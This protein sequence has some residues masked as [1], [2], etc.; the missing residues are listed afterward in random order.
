[1]QLKGGY[2]TKDVRLD[3]VPQFDEKSRDFRVRQMIH[4]GAPLGEKH[5][6]SFTWANEHWLDQGREGR[7][8]EYAIC[9]DL[10]AKPKQVSTTLVQ[11]I[12]DGKRIYWPAQQEDQW[13]GGSYEGGDPSYEGTSVLAGVKVAARLGF[14]QE[15][16]WALTLEGAV[17][18]LGYIGPLILGVNWYEGCF[19]PDNFGWIRLTGEQQGGHSILAIG[20]KLVAKADSLHVTDFASLD[21]DRSFILLHN[22]W[23]QDWGINGRA[24]MSLQDFDRLRQ[25]DGEVCIISRRALPKALP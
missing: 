5:P 9:H 11:Q 4:E 13:P 12:L 22:S 6:R 15:Y 21:L 7:C 24:K 17:L 3:R 18:G 14:Y 25:E 2:E 1:M 19:Q 10:L 20:I 8:V 16:R 23:G